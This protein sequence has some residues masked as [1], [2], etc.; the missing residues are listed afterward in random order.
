MRLYTYVVR[1]DTGFAPNPFFGYCTLACC[2]PGIRRTAR[3]GDWIVGL[4]PKALNSKIVYVMKVEES[5]TFE[6]YYQ[7]KRFRKKIPDLTGNCM[8]RCGDNIYAPQRDGSLR[9]LPSKHSSGNREDRK[10]KKRDLRGKRVLVSSHFSYFGS[11]A[12]VLP[13]GFLE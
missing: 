6:K 9:Q 8:Q 3:V 12:R 1:S 11:K 13:D 7:Y 10:Q 4:T 5:L 2:K